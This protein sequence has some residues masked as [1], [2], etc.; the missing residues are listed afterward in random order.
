MQGTKLE[1]PALSMAVT[2][3]FVKDYI[4]EQDRKL[5]ENFTNYEDHPCEKC[6]GTGVSPDPK[7]PFCIG[8]EGTGIWY[9]LVYGVEDGKP[10]AYTYE[11]GVDFVKEACKLYREAWAGH[12]L[13]GKVPE[14]M[15]PFLLPKTL[16][17]ELEARGYTVRENVADPDAHI[18]MKKAIMNVVAKEYPDF[19][20]VPYTN[21]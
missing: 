16:E 20:C 12:Q 3:T 15:R 21:F 19:M 17:M 10:F 11:Y 13:A 2:E 4:K 5:S 6:G 7:D 18:M 9:R 1:T 8:C 14:N